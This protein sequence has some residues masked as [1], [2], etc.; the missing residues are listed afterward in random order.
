[1]VY[2]LVASPTLFLSVFTLSP[3]TVLVISPGHGWDLRLFPAFSS[4]YRFLLYYRPVAG[5]HSTFGISVFLD[6]LPALLSQRWVSFNICI[7]PFSNRLLPSLQV[8]LNCIEYWDFSLPLIFFH[9]F[10][11]KVR[12][13]SKHFWNLFFLNPLL[14]LDFDSKLGILSY[15][16]LF[17][18]IFKLHWISFSFNIVFFILL[19]TLLCLLQATLDFIQHYLYSYILLIFFPPFFSNAGFHSTFGIFL[20]LKTLPSFLYQRW[21]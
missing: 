11:S 15:L 5:F 6:L 2:T 21:F 9:L 12:F 1:M 14:S 18:H 7:L 19:N 10:V 3:A 20:F 13:H 17:H 4:I 8:T 16:I